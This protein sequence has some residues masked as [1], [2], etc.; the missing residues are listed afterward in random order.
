MEGES[1]KNSYVAFPW[2]F[3]THYGHCICREHEP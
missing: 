3:K 2:A 1:P